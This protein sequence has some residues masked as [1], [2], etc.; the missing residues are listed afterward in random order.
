[1]IRT[2]ARSQVSCERLGGG[3][4][5][6]HEELV[7]ALAPASWIISDGAYPASLCISAITYAMNP[8]PSRIQF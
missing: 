8:R 6:A 1:M 4:M 3:G 5:A 7:A 2:R